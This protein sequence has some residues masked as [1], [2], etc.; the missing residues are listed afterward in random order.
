MVPRARLSLEPPCLG[1][2][3]PDVASRLS[4]PASTPMDGNSAS[5]LLPRGGGT[6]GAATLSSSAAVGSMMRTG[7]LGAAAS[8]RLG[9]SPNIPT[10]KSALTRFYEDGV[11]T[12]SL[13][14]RVVGEHRL[15]D[16]HDFCRRGGT[17]TSEGVRSSLAGR[18]GGRGEGVS[19]SSTAF[20][21]AFQPS[22]RG[23]GAEEVGGNLS[24][25]SDGG[26]YSSNAVRPSSG[27]DGVL[28][29]E[30]PEL[31]GNHFYMPHPISSTR[32][33]RNVLYHDD[34]DIH[35]A[36]HHGWS[37]DFRAGEVSSLLDASQPLVQRAPVVLAETGQ[38][39]PPSGPQQDQR[40]QT[41][42]AKQQLLQKAM[43][44]QGA[45]AFGRAAF[46]LSSSRV[47]PTGTLDIPRLEL[48]GY[49][50]GEEH[51]KDDEEALAVGGLVPVRGNTNLKKTV[52]SRQ[53]SRGVLR[54]SCFNMW[55]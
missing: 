16:Q 2:Y 39:V 30:Y 44:R 28:D 43:N 29:E 48:G 18:A 10:N 33:L 36:T 5:L 37:A 46:T 47:L 41:Q 6:A 23:S 42:Q 21:A 35:P 26:S 3:P 24:Y 11:R 20:A 8:N 49:F 53:H 34:D 4:T 12:D 1:I 27:I 17:T 19:S 52:V 32:W 7:S 51:L 31:L 40:E 38:D 50:V 14:A 55:C 9:S 15:E 54:P 22:D 13:R 45:L 25:S